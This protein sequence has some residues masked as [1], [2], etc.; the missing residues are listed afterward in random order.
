M[1]GATPSQV[2]V[3]GLLDTGADVTIVSQL[4]WTQ[5]WPIVMI[6]TR[7]LGLG[8]VTQSLMAAKPVT[9]WNPEGQ[10]ATV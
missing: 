10:V 2:K 7:V 4:H 6:D 8:G 3:S 9:I 5:S 1:D